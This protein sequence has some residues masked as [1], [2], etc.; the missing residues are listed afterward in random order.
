M[1]EVLKYCKVDNKGNVEEGNGGG[2]K[3][4]YQTVRLGG[5]AVAERSDGGEAVGGV[6]TVGG[7]TCCSATCED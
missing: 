1:N 7:V 2:G 6:V 5:G 4:E 3:A